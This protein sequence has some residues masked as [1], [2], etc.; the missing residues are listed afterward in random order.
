MASEKDLKN[1]LIDD[2]GMHSNLKETQTTIF[3]IACRIMS[4]ILILLG[5]MA[6]YIG[7][8]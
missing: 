3:V 6:L 7:N 5:V 1:G 8:K 4:V 2:T